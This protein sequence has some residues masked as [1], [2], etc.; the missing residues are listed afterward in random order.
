MTAHVQS[1]VLVAPTVD[2]PHAQQEVQNI[3]RSGMQI[4][5][6]FSPVALKD[7]TRELMSGAEDG[8]II[9]AHGNKD[10]VLLDEVTLLS[11]STLVQLVRGR[12]KWV[13]LNSCDSLDLAQQLQNETGAAIICTLIALPDRDAYVTGSLFV[14]SLARHGSV[15]R[16]YRESLPGGNRTYLYLGGDEPEAQPDFLARAAMS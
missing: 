12:F 6:V 10:G 11:G 4:R 13:Y 2:I 16:A 7:F 15:S 8:L 3:L 14:A 9:M 1:A 5:P